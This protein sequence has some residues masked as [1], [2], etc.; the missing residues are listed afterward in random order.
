MDTLGADQTSASDTFRYYVNGNSVN[1][2]NLDAWLTA[3]S[4][5]VDDGT[6]GGLTEQDLIDLRVGSTLID[7]SSGSAAITIQLEESS[8]LSTWSDMGAAGQTTVTVP[9]TGD[10]S[11]FRVRAQ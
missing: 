6:S 5:I 9:M 10:A 7:A 2:T 11:F 4:Y 1:A 3:N 8:D